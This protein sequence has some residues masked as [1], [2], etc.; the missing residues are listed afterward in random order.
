MRAT[1][2]AA[3]LLAALGGQTLAADLPWAPPAG[4]PTIA[5][6]SGFYLGL[7][8]GGGFAS[9]RSAFGVA[10]A[11]FATVSNPLTGAAGGVQA[12][13]NA[14][15]GPLVYGLEAD[16]QAS[17]LK[18]AISAPCAAGLCGI[19]LTADYSQRV[20]W[21]GTVRGRFGYA[22]AG[23]LI[24][25]TGGYA[26]A[27]VETEATATAGAA[28]AAVS[29]KDIRSGW[30]AGGGIE[31]ALT[32]HWS[33]RL[34]YLYADLGSRQTEFVF[35]GLPVVTDDARLDMSVVRAGVNYRF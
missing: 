35:T 10:G 24:Y 27:R 22:A 5:D 6:W 30:T 1:I 28:T 33:A 11:T 23:W 31:V 16:F 3:S 34:E 13:W 21:F 15:A 4:P 7:N 12:G 17:S 25:A 18:G 14:Q 9:G 19:A 2:I 29:F 26:Y 20:P 8:G 32:G